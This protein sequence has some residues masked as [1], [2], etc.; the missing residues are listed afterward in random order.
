MGEMRLISDG[1]S[2]WTWLSLRNQYTRKSISS[3][4]L[5]AR[6]NFG[7]GTGAPAETA[8]AR[9]R[10]LREEQIVTSGVSHECWVVEIPFEKIPIPFPPGT[11]LRDGTIQAWIDRTNHVVW[12]MDTN[13]TMYSGGKSQSMRA[14]QSLVM[15]SVNLDTEISDSLFRFVPPPGATQVAEFGHPAARESNLTGK[16]AP[17]LTV[18]TLDGGRYDLAALRGK[19]ILLDF[20]TT[21]CEPCK[22]GMKEL[23][24]LY[25]QYA[26]G[27]VVVGLS[28]GEARETVS[29]FL[30]ENAVSYPIAL[31]DAALAGTFD[32]GT[33]PTYLVIDR[34]GVVS[35]HLRGAAGKERVLAALKVAGL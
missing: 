20:W 13:G 9:A 29:R 17:P 22:A 33:L 24:S 28:V 34:N 19:V 3:G 14:R 23:D 15:R 32:A 2:V 25:R 7:L 16:S 11:E 12:R 4:V 6:R 30:A 8:L 21:W 10:T 27:L 1:E 31:V 18:E 35:A 26:D 5:D